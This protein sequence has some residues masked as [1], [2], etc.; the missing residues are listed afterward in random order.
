VVVA[1][2]MVVADVASRRFEAPT[3]FTAPESS[4][5]TT[6]PST[7]AAAKPKEAEGDDFAARLLKAKKKARDEM[8][9]HKEG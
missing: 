1:E 2:P 5:P 8:D 6:K 9:E 3:D 7:S 4:T